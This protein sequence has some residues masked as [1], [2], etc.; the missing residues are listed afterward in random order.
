MASREA[1]EGKECVR[2]QLKK[3]G[4]KRRSAGWS[5]EEAGMRKG[6]EAQMQKAKESNEDWGEEGIQKMRCE[7]DN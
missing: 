5:G 6:Q 3:S 2:E 1:G 7:G 4:M